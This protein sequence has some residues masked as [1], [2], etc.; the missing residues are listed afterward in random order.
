MSWEAIGAIGEV[1]GAIAVK[2]TGSF[3]LDHM[4]C[5]GNWH[6]LQLRIIQLPGV[7]WRRGNQPQ[8]GDDEQQKDAITHSFIINF[9][10]NQLLSLT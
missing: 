10:Y 9:L 6:A 1:V 7:H 4:Q 8:R 3:Y 5:R 2:V